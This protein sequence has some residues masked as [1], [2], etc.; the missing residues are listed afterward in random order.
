MGSREVGCADCDKQI[1]VRTWEDRAG[2]ALLWDTAHGWVM[3][4]CPEHN[5]EKRRQAIEYPILS[6]YIEGVR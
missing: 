1:T 5:S 3:G 2:W 4:L 6:Q